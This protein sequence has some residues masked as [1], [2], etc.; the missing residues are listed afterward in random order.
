LG[1]PTYKRVSK[2]L[3]QFERSSVLSKGGSVVSEVRVSKVAWHYDQVHEKLALMTKRV[4]D[5]TGNGL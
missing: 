2:L 1:V 3:F 4:E 5:M